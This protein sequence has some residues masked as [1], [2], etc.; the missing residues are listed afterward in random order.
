M[1]SGV[2][3]R[4]K[5]ISLAFCVLQFIHGCKG[6]EPNTRLS[7]VCTA[8]GEYFYELDEKSVMPGYPKLI[9]DMWGISGP[10]DAAFT[11]INCQGK[12]YIF[13]VCNMSGQFFYIS[14]TSSTGL[15]DHKIKDFVVWP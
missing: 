14:K 11:R 1:P 8:L 12:S 2:R 10:I 5:M 3:L 7:F 9:K 13:K 15:I 6:Y 4:A